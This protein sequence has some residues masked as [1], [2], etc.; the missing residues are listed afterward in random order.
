LNDVTAT[1]CCIPGLAALLGES[2]LA[3]ISRTTELATYILLTEQVLE[4]L[5][6]YKRFAQSLLDVE[7]AG[8]GDGT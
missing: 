8:V 7:D 5:L 3:T 1:L 6:W 2:T 4:T